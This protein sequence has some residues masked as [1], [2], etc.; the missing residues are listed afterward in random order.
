M[1]TE[2]RVAQRKVV[3]AHSCPKIVGL[4]G[5]SHRV[6]NNSAEEQRSRVHLCTLLPQKEL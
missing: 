6:G 1:K 2:D 3:S 5:E 4:V